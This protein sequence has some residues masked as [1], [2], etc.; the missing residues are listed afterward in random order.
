MPNIRSI[1][2]LI[3]FSLFLSCKKSEQMPTVT[4]VPESVTDSLPNV[5]QD[6]QKDTLI[7][8]THSGD[9]VLNEILTFVGKMEQQRWISDTL[10]LKKLHQ[11]KYLSTNS[12]HYINSYP[13]YKVAFDDARINIDISDDDRVF[14]QQAQSI[15]DYFYYSNKKSDFISDGIIEQ[16]EFNDEEQAKKALNIIR[17]Y[18]INIY[19]NTNPFACRVKNY[20]IIF[21]TRAMAFSYDQ[22]NVFKEFIKE[23]EIKEPDFYKGPY[24]I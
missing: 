3:A 19:F 7:N 17:D 8:E 1:S 14:M 12:I 24:G 18:G 11:Y 9:L 23:N 20:L 15:V 2:I 16:W 5:I 10:R 13:F 6:N 21:H 22:K 4:T